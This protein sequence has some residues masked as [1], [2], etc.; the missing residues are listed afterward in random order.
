[1]T[2]EWKKT[3][4]SVVQEMANGDERKRSFNGLNERA[5][6]DQISQF[7]EVIGNLTGEPV[8][9]VIVSR[10]ETIKTEA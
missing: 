2:V 4:I 7:A 3:S 5:T 1:M 9:Q 8:M 10:A 6:D